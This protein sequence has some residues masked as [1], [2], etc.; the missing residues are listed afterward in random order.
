MVGLACHGWRTAI[1]GTARTRGAGARGSAAEGTAKNSASPTAGN[2]GARRAEGAARRLEVAAKNE[3]QPGVD[4]AV[5]TLRRECD[6]A[7][8]AI[9]ERIMG[10][11][12]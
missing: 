9:R 1:G 2:F 3:D 4:D 7:L 11:P 10:V 8:A 5:A 6:E 12:A